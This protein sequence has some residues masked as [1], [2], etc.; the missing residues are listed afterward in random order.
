MTLNRR[1]FLGGALGGASLLLGA[2]GQF[3]STANAGAATV[4]ERMGVLEAGSLPF[5]KRPPGTDQVPEIDHFV[6]LMMENHSFDNILGLIGR[7]NGFTLGS[8]GRPTAKNPDGHGNDVHAFHMPTECQTDGVGNDWK[9]THEAYDGGSCQGFV[10]STTPEAMGYFTK[11]DLPYSCGMASVFPIADHYF[12]STMAQTDPNRRYLIAGTS[13]GLINDTF[14]SELPPNG[15]IFEQFNK[16][17]ISWKDYY[18]NLPTLGVFLPLLSDP[19]LRSGVVK[20]D[21]FFEDAAAGKLPAFSLVEPDYDHQSEE[22]PQDIQYGDQF[23]GKVVNAVDVQP[24]LA[25]DHADL[26]L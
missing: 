6:V 12:C 1:Q 21:Q 16:H 11:D 25:Q 17:G 14:P 10:T 7:G 3:A 13:L 22:N 19:A 5:P 4:S 23:V 8:D 15:V 2:S 24:Q 26:D 18:S 9:V 20:I